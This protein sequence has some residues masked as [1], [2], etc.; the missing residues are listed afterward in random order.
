MDVAERVLASE[1]LA[2]DPVAF[3]FHISRCRKIFCHSLSATLRRAARGQGQLAVHLLELFQGKKQGQ[4]Y[5]FQPQRQ[6]DKS[7]NLA[8]ILSL[9]KR[10]VFLAS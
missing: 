2:P 6:R 5:S 3:S 4:I 9:C 10:W 8:L 7:E 1:L